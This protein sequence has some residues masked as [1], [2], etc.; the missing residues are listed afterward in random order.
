M[1]GPQNENERLNICKEQFND[2]DPSNNL[3]YFIKDGEI[4]CLSSIEIYYIYKSATTNVRNNNELGDEYRIFD[5]PHFGEIPII[6]T[7]KLKYD[8]KFNNIFEIKSR[9][10]ELKKLQVLPKDLENIVGELD[11]NGY[12]IVVKNDDSDNI[13]RNS[14]SDLDEKIQ[15]ILT[16]DLQNRRHNIEDDLFL[17]EDFFPFVLNNYR[18]NKNV[19]TLID[20]ENFEMDNIDYITLAR[21][22]NYMNRHFEN[23]NYENVL[24][25]GGH[26]CGF[27]CSSQNPNR[28]LY[29]YDVDIFLYGIKDKNTA[30]E[31]LK[32]IITY[33]S[34]RMNVYNINISKNCVTLHTGRGIKVDIVTRLYNTKSEILHGF[35]IG[36]SAVGWDGTNLLFTSLSRFSYEHKVII[37]D[38]SRR[39]TTFEKR[40]IKYQK[41][42]HFNLI[43]PQFNMETLNNAKLFTKMGRNY[44]YIT[45]P[46]L[47]LKVKKYANNFILKNLDQRQNIIGHN[48]PIALS[49][50][51]FFRLNNILNNSDCDY[52]PNTSELHNIKCLITNNLQ[53]I[54]YKINWNTNTINGGERFN[55]GKIFP[56]N[57]DEIDYILNEEK[58]L[59]NVEI[60]F[61]KIITFSL[62]TR[63]Q[64]MFGELEK[65]KVLRHL[66][67]K[68]ILINELDDTQ[69]LT[70][71]ICGILSNTYL[72]PNS[73]EIMRHI[74]SG[75]ISGREVPTFLNTIIKENIEKIKKNI[76]KINSN[77]KVWDII[78]WNIQDPTTQ[79]TSSVNPEIKN[80]EDWYGVYY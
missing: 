32:E 64:V 29:Q 51:H 24:I 17:L 68:K 10:E 5:F 2:Y 62:P 80:P 30:E 63:L 1:Q 12:E 36:P 35:D 11:S 72:F 58:I 22:S 74:L 55:E 20:D 71:L 61:N 6:L 54:Y 26:I 19:F 78:N 16:I 53:D 7:N 44:L 33:F 8:L 31:R 45:M 73:L 15:E 13:I 77:N 66:I 46:Y 52:K 75:Q 60:Y 28:L 41:R 21:F 3:K 59:E 34:E 9:M 39:S 56:E 40:L 50:S 43:L 42:T 18:N 57:V 48:K 27:L 25:A 49:L 37:V 4:L 76:K 79:L 38:L 67:D 23:F 69:I 47:K 65:N 14:I 70:N